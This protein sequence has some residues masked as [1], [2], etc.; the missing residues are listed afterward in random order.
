MYR[1][2]MKRVAGLALAA[3]LLASAPAVAAGGPGSLG[4]LGR[5]WQWV[6]SFWADD[7]LCIDPNGSPCVLRPNGDEGWHIDPDG[8]RSTA[9]NGACIDPNGCA[10]RP[11]GDDGWCIDPDG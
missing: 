2:G 10:P 11:N 4:F 3:M 1:K 7:G 8:A 6:Q 9:E 5:A